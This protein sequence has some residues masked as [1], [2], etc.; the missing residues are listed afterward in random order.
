MNILEK[1]LDLL[2]PLVDINFQQL[3]ERKQLKT[4]ATF[5]GSFIFSFFIISHVIFILLADLSLSLL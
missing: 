2:S 4:S 5:S 3:K 1:K